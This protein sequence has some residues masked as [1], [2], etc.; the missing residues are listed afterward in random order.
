MRTHRIFTFC[1]VIFALFVSADTARA[2]SCAVS[3]TVD[4]AFEKTPNVAVFK[5]QS[6][7]K[8]VEGEKGY[9]S[10]GIKQSKLTVE[11]VYKGNLK[12][13]QQLTFAQGSG[14]DCVWTFDDKSIGEKYL[15]Y[16]GAK[17]ID[18]KSSDGIIAWTGQINKPVSNNVWMAITCSRSG[19][20]D[21]RSSDLKYLENISKVRG[22][23]RLSGSLSQYISTAT[24][25]EESKSNQL[26][27]YKVIVSG[28][29]KN[30]ELK[31]DENGVYE[32]YDLP[33]G[34]P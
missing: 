9:G 32:I 10:G 12:V 29:G 13:G 33:A 5:L 14:A 15:F 23:T 1:G 24:E 31:T 18:N 25:D 19:N 26:S 17:P 6:V 8:L 21:Y 30:L 11:K 3:P 28:N 2:C 34:T 27:G 20:I 7:E 22:K 16:L 4:I